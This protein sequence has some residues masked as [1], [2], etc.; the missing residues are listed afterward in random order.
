MYGKQSYKVGPGSLVGEIS[1]FFKTKRTATVVN[2]TNNRVCFLSRQ[3]KKLFS[4]ICP[5]IV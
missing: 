4:I 1:Y 5:R 3:N 2:V